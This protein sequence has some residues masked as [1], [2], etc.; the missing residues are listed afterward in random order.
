MEE[1]EQPLIVDLP[2]PSFMVDPAD[3]YEEPLL[4]EDEYEEPLTL[5]ESTQEK[6]LVIPQGPDN[7][8]YVDLEGVFKEY[9]RKLVKEDIVNDD[10]L[11]EVVRSSLESRF[12]PGG[13]LT[14]AR[15][16][17]TGLAGGTIGGLSSQD[18]REMS[19]EDVFETW[20]NYQRSFSGGQTVT[21]ANELT[22]GLGADDNIK[23]K[24]GAGYMLFDQMDNA[25]TGEGSWGE[26]GDA[27]LDYGKAAVY[28]PSTILSLG[29]G[30]VLGFS[31]TK[32]SSAASRALMINAAKDQ[33]KKGVAKASATKA[34]GQA[35]AK[36]LPYATADALIGAGVDVAYQSQLI[37]VG[38]QQDYSK[39]QT[40]LAA[41]G[42]LIIIP[43]LVGLG[44][45]AKELRK[46]NLAPQ[47]LAYK[48]F[49]ADLLKIT[50][51]E[52]KR[53]LAKRVDK[54]KLIS[55][56]NDNFD[57]K[58]SDPKEFLNWEEIKVQAELGIEMRG[59]EVINP[60]LLDSFLKRFWFGD[61]SN[62]GYYQALKDSGWVIH[63]AMIEDNTVTGV[64]GEAIRLL[65]DDT[66]ASAMKS[67]EKST[68]EKIGIQYSADALADTFQKRTSTAGSILW[69]P[70]QLSRLE[71]ANVKADDAV[72]ILGGKTKKAKDLP[73]RHQFTLSL[74]KRLL[75]SHLSTTGANLKGFTQLVSLNTAADFATG[76]INLVQGAG[77]RA[78]GN[79]DAAEKYYN[80]AYGS[81]IGALR[82]GADVFSPDIPME[83]ADK[84][85]ALKPEVA[86]RLF[87]DIAGDG[88]VR[89]GIKDFNL[90]KIKY[91][92]FF[93]GA[94][95]VEKL[96]WKGANE[97]TK[98]A[99]ALTGVR[100]QDSLTKRWAFGT[101]VNQA[102]MRAYGETPE[103]FFARS[104]AALEMASD[105]FKEEVLDK[106]VFRTMRETAAVNWSSLPGKEAMMSART[107][108]KGVETLTN[109]SILGYIVPFG[110]FL[111]TTVATMA[112]LT[113]INA[114]RFAVK[115][116]TG[117]ELDFVTREGAESLGK[118]AAGWSLI[119]I[120]IGVKGG[121]RDR[122]ENNL[123]HNQ[124]MQDDGSIQNRQYDWPASTMRLM[125]Q[126]GAHG[127]GDS[128][129]IADF[130]PSQVP[131]DLIKEL[132]IQIGGQAVRDLDEVGQTITYAGEQIVN[133]GNYQPFI[134]MLG[135]VPARFI[136]GVTRPLDPVNQ[137]W[138]MVSDGKMNPDLRQGGETQNQMLRYINNITGT[139]KDLPTRATPTRGTDFTPDT[140]KQ[141]LGVRGLKTPNLI[142]KMMNAAGRPYWK[143][144]RFDGPPEI[145]N[146]M[147]N[148]AAPFFEATA[149][150]YLKRNPNYFKLDLEDKEKILDNI[151][152][153]VK[154]DV[155]S[156]VEQ[157]MPRSINIV[158]LLSR[159][160][161]KTK[162]VMEFLD[163]EGSPE[164]LLK[165]D[166][167]LQQ[168]LK[169]KSLVD[170][171][172]DIFYGDLNLE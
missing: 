31:A 1:Y 55:K 165:Q 85:F 67:F 138:G 155:M 172:D 113:G 86:E 66:V 158:R 90:D 112:D 45:S 16:G 34:I 20:Q 53:K 140:G 75:T 94:E 24:L 5:G 13:V 6:T 125:S 82:K 167:G 50:P 156:V 97:V 14:K 121:A 114:M 27:M 87:K 151:A 26:M 79:L 92:N 42:S 40:S 168:L 127:L 9:G 11:M 73:A 30:K 39:L 131:A 10:R 72:A 137:V 54:K 74:Y 154:K 49:D 93:A 21:T 150:E 142:E 81:V 89:D 18:Y 15:R 104:D 110:S 22:Y 44:A 107:W 99:Q 160:K 166:G 23:A 116:V 78:V 88:G 148:L 133:E 63:E 98:G 43:T 117:Q 48:E 101:N 61:E 46:S 144:I 68:G 95:D 7:S 57:A 19:N 70:S 2:K 47:W 60:E 29:L 159:N 122:I 51:E 56:T 118:M 12:T 37:N 106:A 105:K 100:L 83:Y 58:T 111:N 130:D 164:D 128:N 71:R 136:Q 33:A 135:A 170:S 157:G 36:S 59:E 28:D 120:G 109:R 8:S 119:G 147:D 91:D 62:N 64:F 163:I 102:I 149:I 4:I 169:I 161:K 145:K 17:L 146:K 103:K 35:V 25:F 84:I 41:A 134:D 3:E 153:D 69:T 76:A 77:Y 32:A 171:Y 141:I 139:S 129:N 143:A 38:V 52:A 65:P 132:G 152:T 162:K 108:A 96:A 80:R 123:A 126:I 115:K 124:D